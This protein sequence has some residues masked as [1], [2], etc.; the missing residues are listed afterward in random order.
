MN[1][2][3]GMPGPMGPDGINP[4]MMNGNGK[5]FDTFFLW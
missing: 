1:Q 4:A 3:A 2:G 5:I